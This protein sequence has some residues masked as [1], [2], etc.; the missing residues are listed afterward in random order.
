MVLRGREHRI[1]VHRGLG[2]EDFLSQVKEKICMEANVI[3]S[4]IWDRRVSPLLDPTEYDSKCCP[5]IFSKP[6]PW[7]PGG[8]E[9]TVYSPHRSSRKLWSQ[10]GWK[11][12]ELHFLKSNV[13]CIRNTMLV[14]STESHWEVQGDK[15]FGEKMSQLSPK[16]GHERP[17]S[18]ASKEERVR[19]E[20][21]GWHAVWMPSV[22]QGA[23]RHSFE[24]KDV[25]L[26][27]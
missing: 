23:A 24:G 9:L 2:S 12:Q 15:H 22:S 1:Q 8:N 25:N 13:W 14:Q 17:P 20:T 27:G 18:S 16:L 5:S 10:L 3:W 19:A 7:L 21:W 6:E 4:C 11:I 26:L